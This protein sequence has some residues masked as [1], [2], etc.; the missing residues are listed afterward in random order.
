MAVP[1]YISL[2]K[3]RAAAFRREA[4]LL[5]AEYAARRL[6]P[7][8]QYLWDV[9]Q[10]HYGGD[11]LGGTAV[12]RVDLP[13]V[14]AEALAWAYSRDAKPADVRQAKSELE[15]ALSEWHAA[16]KALAQSMSLTVQG[17]SATHWVRQ[18]I[19]ASAA[20]CEQA[21]SSLA[22]QWPLTENDFDPAILKE[23]RAGVGIDMGDAFALLAGVGGEEWH[24]MVA[25]HPR[26][27][28]GNAK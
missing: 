1:F 15:A 18:V 7:N 4:E 25:A 6:D 21:K 19:T 5:A 8:W 23:L 27:Q 2:A 26:P 13:G 22:T 20:R 11:R 17:L 16:W 28:T 9:L 3:E 24:K 12:A 10:P 14:V